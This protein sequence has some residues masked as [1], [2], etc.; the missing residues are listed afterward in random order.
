MLNSI[1]KLSNGGCNTS[2]FVVAWDMN[3]TMPYPRAFVGEPEI[4]PLIETLE[5]DE[6]GDSQ[7]IAVRV[8]KRE[9]KE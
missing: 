1:S 9:E 2:S 6:D 4:I 3:S 7:E 8:N 5:I